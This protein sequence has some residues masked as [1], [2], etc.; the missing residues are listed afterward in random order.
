MDNLYEDSLARVCV[1]KVC[2][3]DWRL[4]LRD[5]VEGRAMTIV[6]GIHI[7]LCGVSVLLGLGLLIHRVGFKGHRFFD[8]NMSK[9]CFR[10]KPIDCMVLFIVIFNALRGLSSAILIADVF[11]DMVSRSFLFE[12]P[13]QF[14][15][16]SFAL[17]LIGIAQTLSDSHRVLATSWLPSPRVV[18]FVG[19]YIFFSPFV[20]NNVLAIIAGVMAE[21]NLM[22]SRLLTRLLYIMWFVHCSSL[23]VAVIFAGVRLIAILRD[24]LS[25]FNTSGPR[26]VSVQTGIFKIR[27]VVTIIAICLMMFAVFL[28]LFGILR[29]IIIVNLLGS[30]ILGAVWNYLGVVA[31]TGV[32]IAVLV[33]PK[34]DDNADLGL[35]TSS[36]EKSGKETSQFATFSNFSAQEYAA[37][38]DISHQNGAKGT[39]SHNAFDEL[40]MQQIQYQ[41]VFQKHNN[42]QSPHNTIPEK[43]IAQMEVSPSGIPY[44]DFQY[45]G[46]NNN[47]N[48]VYQPGQSHID[49]DHALDDGEHSQMDLVEYAAKA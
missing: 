10:P 45:T 36:A 6:H 1:N 15:F 29:E 49:D 26:Y 43:Q 31:T 16:G 11:P 14:G 8:V 18:D 32:L 20:V 9:G 21:R 3:C 47:N 48:N 30:V 5:C 17:Y 34:I 46:S 35:K 22:V 33:N 38:N 7:A 13:W 25:K 4:S 23:S 12:F 24:H 42:H 44:E 27:A 41:K 28:L 39:L 40:K 2:H 37:P 19:G